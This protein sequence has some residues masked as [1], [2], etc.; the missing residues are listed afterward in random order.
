MCCAS[1]NTGK[2]IKSCTSTAALY[3]LALRPKISVGILAN[4]F[5]GKKCGVSVPH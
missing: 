4:M 3:V 2:L 1:I 5:S